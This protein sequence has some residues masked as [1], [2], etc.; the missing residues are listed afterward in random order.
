MCCSRRKWEQWTSPFDI[1]VNY[2]S[3]CL[4]AMVRYAPAFFHSKGNLSIFGNLGHV[5]GSTC[6]PSRNWIF[7][8]FWKGAFVFLPNLPLFPV[9]L[10]L[11]ENVITTKVLQNHWTAGKLKNVCFNSSIMCFFVPPVVAFTLQRTASRSQR[12]EKKWRPGPVV[13]NF[14]LIRSVLHTDESSHYSS[15]VLQFCMRAILQ[16]APPWFKRLD[17]KRDIKGVAVSIIGKK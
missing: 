11:L 17:V 7:E 8:V 10:K 16:V 9:V 4:S 3:R 6:G 1:V 13:H 2:T 15:W 14:E 5:S 12:I